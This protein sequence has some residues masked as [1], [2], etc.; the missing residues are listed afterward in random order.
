[1]F[2]ARALA[3][4][5]VARPCGARRRLRAGRPSASVPHAPP[6]ALLCQRPRATLGPA[7]QC[8]SSD[9][10]ATTAPPWRR[11]R[12]VRTADRRSIRGAT[13]TRAGQGAV[14]RRNQRRHRVVTP[15]PALYIRP[16]CFSSLHA[17]P[18]APDR[19]TAPPWPLPASHRL[20]SPP[21][22]RAHEQTP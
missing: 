11:T 20:A 4:R 8:L 15:G 10:G 14:V 7:S 2:Q 13:R 6:D 17:I 12:A 1:M 16:P 5:D 22:H 18:A 3:R 19:R 21:G 9:R